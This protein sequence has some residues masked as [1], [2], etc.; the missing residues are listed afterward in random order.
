MELYKLINNNYKV[1]MMEIKKILD[2][3]EKLSSSEIFRFEDDKVILIND[4]IK[5]FLTTDEIKY[6]K[7]ITKRVIFGYDLYNFNNYKVFF[8]I[9]NN[10]KDLY[11]EVP[12]NVKNY[13][14]WYKGVKG[15]HND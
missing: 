14:H 6:L 12:L 5:E 9:Q 13:E 3:I 10:V 7:K 11:F 15:I 1:K 8:K 2:K 4:E